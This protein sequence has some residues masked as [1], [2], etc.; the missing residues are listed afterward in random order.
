MSMKTIIMVQAK[1]GSTRLPNKIMEK[2]VGIPTIQIILKRLKKTR[3]ADKVIVVTSNNKENKEL[4][5]YLKKVKTSYF[6][7]SENDVVNRFYK[8]ANK[9][10]AEILTKPLNQKDYKNC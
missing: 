8:A 5:E 4:I 10:K 9:Y 3:E 2:I 6:C 1:M 7:G